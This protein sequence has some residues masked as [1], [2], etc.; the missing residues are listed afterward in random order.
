[1]ERIGNA[2]IYPIDMKGT[3][4]AMIRPCVEGYTIYVDINLPQEEQIAAALHELSHISRNDFEK[5]N[6]QEIEA[7]SHNGGKS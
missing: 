1:M 2:F 6:V 3:A 5:E 7:E 4:R